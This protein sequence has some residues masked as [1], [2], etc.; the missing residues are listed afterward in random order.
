MQIVV[1]DIGLYQ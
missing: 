1:C